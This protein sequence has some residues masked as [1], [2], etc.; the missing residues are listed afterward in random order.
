MEKPV[1]NAIVRGLLNIIAK[2]K[3]GKQNRLLDQI[4][5]LDLNLRMVSEFV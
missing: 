2:M 4:T 1:C 5:E 3:R